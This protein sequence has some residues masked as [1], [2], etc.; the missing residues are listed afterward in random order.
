MSAAFSVSNSLLHICSNSS[1]CQTCLYHSLYPVWQPWAY[2]LVF[3]QLASWHTDVS[4]WSGGQPWSL[5]PFHR[6]K[7]YWC[8]HTS[9]PAE[10][11]VLA[12]RC[13]RALLHNLQLTSDR[14]LILQAIWLPEWSPK[15]PSFLAF[16]VSKGRAGRSS[17]SLKT[18]CF[19]F[20]VTWSL[21]STY[22]MQGDWYCLALS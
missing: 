5:S 13:S 11:S 2:A 19:H 3:V 8:A 6:R 9:L 4:R 22:H 1:S 15:L 20:A 10:I 17:T 7:H 18:L 16:Y 14:C 12:L 21:L